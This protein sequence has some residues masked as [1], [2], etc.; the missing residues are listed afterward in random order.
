MWIEADALCGDNG[1][2]LI[3]INSQDE[4]DFAVECKFYSCLY[5]TMQK[6][7]QTNRHPTKCILGSVLLNKVTLEDFSL[8]PRILMDDV[9]LQIKFSSDQK[10]LTRLFILV[11]EFDS[12]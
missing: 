6:N 4:N 3:S 2:H 11:F 1:G 5:Q 7:N 12:S 9:S 10:H 8:I